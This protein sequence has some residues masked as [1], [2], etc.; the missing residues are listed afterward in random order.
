[1]S[2]MDRQGSVIALMVT[3]WLATASASAA[4]GPLSVR[5]ISPSGQDVPPGKQL[6]IQF[7]RPMVALGDMK[8]RAP[9]FP[10]HISPDPGCEWRWLDTSEL[11]CRMPGQGTLRPATR[12]T[13]SVGTA[14]KALDGTHLSQPLTRHFTTQRPKAEWASFQRW[15]SPVMPVYSV[16]FNMPVTAAEVA[17]HLLF[18]E[19][20]SSSGGVPAKVTPFTAK[21]QG[22]L[23]LPVPGAPGAMLEV[24]KPLPDTPL[25]A[26]QPAG[27]ARRVWKVQPARALEADADYQ[28]RLTAG[29]ATP[30]GQLPGERGVVRG[31]E[32]LHTF[33]AF[34][35]EGIQCRRDGAYKWV[36]VAPGSQTSPRCVPGSIR[37]RFSAPVSR[38]VL[39][40]SQWSPKPEVNLAERWKHYPQWFLRMPRSPGAGGQAH[41]Y[42]LTFRMGAMGAYAVTIPAGVKDRFGRTLA[43]ASTV[44]FRTGHF[45][46]FA[47][48]PS[49]PAVLEAGLP[50]V[51]PIRFT[52]LDRFD[53]R[54]RTLHASDLGAAIIDAGQP[55]GT[56][57]LKRP[58]LN[59]TH[60]HIARGSMGVRSMLGGRSGVLAGRLNWSAPNLDRHIDQ[61]LLQVTPYQVF[62]KLG[63]FN[64][65][66][67][68]SRFQ[69]GKPVAGAQVRLLSGPRDELMPLRTAAGHSVTTDAQGLAVLPGTDAL[70]KSWLRSWGK[71]GRAFYVSIVSGKDMA[72]LPLDYSF[73]R[74]VSEA[75]HGDFWSR[76]QPRFGHMRVWAVTS[77]GIY[78]PG[79][80]VKLSVF[81][82]NQNNA[83]LVVPPAL[84]YTLKIT[85]PT[86]HVV[87][88][89]EHARLG[90]FGDLDSQWHV[91]AN[92]PTG[93]YD[94]S[95]AWPTS[96]GTV[97]QQAGRFMVTEFVPSPFKVQAMLEGVR[98]GPGDR[99]HASASARLHAGGPYTD[100]KV[101]F[102]TRL[103]R[104]P[105]AP[106]T[107]LASGFQFGGMDH[108]TPDTRTLDRTDTTLDHAGNASLALPLPGNS[109]MIYGQVQV[110]A[111]VQSSR[112]T[113][114][115]GHAQAVYAARDRFVG[116]RT[117]SWLQTAEKPFSVEYLVVD[118]QGAAQAG[119]TVALKLERRVISSV[120]V[121]NAAGEFEPQQ[122]TTWQTEDQ[123][124]A[125]SAKAP[126][127][128]SLTPSHPGSYRVLASVTDTA[129]RV[130][131]TQLST[132]VAGAGQV[133]W[134]QDKG[135]TLVPDKAHYQV[136][137]TAHVLVQNPYPGA[138]ALITVERYGVLWKKMLTLRGG[139][140]VIDIPV[141]KAMFPG[142][143]LSVAIF[144]P[145]AAPPADPDLGK[146]EVA[147]G[148]LPLHVRGKGAALKV[149]VTPDQPVHKPRQTVQATVKVRTQQGRAPGRTRVVVAVIDQAVLDLLP[150][151][152]KTYN[153][154]TRFYAP[155]QAPDISN[156][157]LAEQLITRLQPRDGKGDTPGGGGGSAGPHVRSQFKAAVYWNATLTTTPQGVVKVHFKLPDNLTRWRIIAVAM[158]PGAAMGW[159]DGSVRVNLPIQLQPALPNQVHV[160]DQFQAGFS[161]TNRTDKSH[162][163]TV[164]LHAQGAIQGGNTAATSQLKLTSFG[165]GLSWLPVTANAPGR[166][167]FSARAESGALGDAMTTIIPVRRAVAREVAA[168]YGS[169]TGDSVQVPVKLPAGAVPG[170]ARLQVNL[171]PTLLGHLDGAFAHLRDDP[172]HTWEIRLS[173][174]VLASDYLRLK[175]VLGDTLDWPDA[176]ADVA[177]VLTRAADYQAPDG[178]MAFWIPRDDFVSPYLSVYT[179]LA[180]NWLHEA[181]HAP[182][183]GV[184]KR[185]HAYLKKH[186]IDKSAAD[187]DAV[188][189]ILRVG[190]MAAL[191]PHGQLPKGSVAG[192]LPQLSKLN[193]FGRALL[194]DAALDSHDHDSAKVVLNSLLSQADESAGE[195]SFNEPRADDYVQL[196]AT[197]L[198]ANCTVL[199]ALV[200][201]KSEIGDSGLLGKTPQKL[202]RWING[203]QRNAGGWP[204]SQ[205]NVFCSTALVHYA[206]VYETPVK[207]LSGTVSM[208]GQAL[209]QVHFASR[210]AAGKAITRTLAADT[211]KAPFKLVV[212]HA[213]QGRLYYDVRLSYAMKPQALGATDAGLSVGRAYFVEHGSRWTRVKPGTVLKRGDLVRVELSVDAP[214]ERHYVVVDDPLPG[215][216]EAV[217]RQLATAMDSTPAAQPGVAVL[218][219]DGGAWPNMSI[220][221]GGFYHRETALD[222]VRFYADDL[223]AGH[224]KLVYSAQ[225]IS[226]GRFIAPASSVRE[227]YQ[228]DVFG[229][230]RAQHLRV[231]AVTTP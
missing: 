16:R 186:I 74:S 85:D 210:Q 206:D 170:S 176:K 34:T 192:M 214:T 6:V 141:R 111:A 177:D 77:Q 185:L 97:E 151:G 159:G 218:M 8:V 7:D 220:V 126:A 122:K 73:Q 184:V 112:G 124:K 181:G 195:L 93:W 145:R 47:D 132:W 9:S 144:S 82:R 213:G 35:F 187:N 171:A 15:A 63:H 66:V 224:Y 108:D 88:K 205:E 162:A 166:I 129:G 164:H 134:P 196:L 156:Y 42:P 172:L 53:F 175:P 190:A 87:L 80:D 90:A 26:H 51:A 143:Y 22:P 202:V 44:R 182:P 147:L 212:K 131:T 142:A 169:L 48:L 72:L 84:D 25:D 137:D 5:R 23:W 40:A 55:S 4:D 198:R 128:C 221:Q 118:P 20:K 211:V 120:Q 14:L 146:P 106:D 209:G 229:R 217:N 64:S 179:A 153:P 61:A 57:L 101:R 27:K 43:K 38:R 89:K 168:E 92:A 149:S 62:A 136:G 60:D 138:K 99:L 116:L 230:G 228:P 100:A 107:P 117:D 115:A 223:P 231:K 37:L 65:L 200:R 54:Y 98:F 173:R 96:T 226:A 67:W 130:Q 163:V 102:T 121:K 110:E 207:A 225:V 13:V 28:M 95:L 75:S 127:S 208:A 167:R 12:Y 18:L 113:R 165:H 91:G 36:A 46:P 140:P 41:D 222:A 150:H 158:S 180:F 193:L 154:L 215:A 56:D 161:T 70:G 114:V 71:H 199:D 19:P 188:A 78:R 148:Y 174:G 203:Q 11:S 189:T 178:G 94:V 81:V 49:L 109:D 58:G 135:V 197:P 204:N 119:S 68:V 201:Y 152:A 50:T 83:S 155:P 31:A 139:A 76:Q 157:S 125:V 10:V 21:R 105:F 24:A 52:N 1:M 3:L 33:G 29:L 216:F 17:A 79:S 194:L 39:A 30:L 86:G 103:V 191:A 32:H 227:I 133:L 160:G 219:F 123:C 69:D 2:G 59:V 45:E 183:A 104:K